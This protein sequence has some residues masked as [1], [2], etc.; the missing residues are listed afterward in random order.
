MKWPIRSLKLYLI[1]KYGQKAA[2]R[3]FELIQVRRGTPEGRRA[4]RSCAALSDQPPPVPVPQLVIIRSLLAVQPVVTQDKH[5][6]ELYG[7]QPA[8]PPPPLSTRVVL[9]DRPCC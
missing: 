1:S 3:C 9:V 7:E 4:G 5:C 8:A 2:N 6:F